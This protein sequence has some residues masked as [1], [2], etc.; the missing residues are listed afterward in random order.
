MYVD[1]TLTI[2]LSKAQDEALTK[3]A[4]VSGKTR[5]ELVREFIDVGLE[6]V[7]LGHRIGHVKG[8]LNLHEPKDALR[9]RI[10]NRNWR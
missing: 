6:E 4:R 9:R 5:S 3:K 7:P 1:K 2:R 8:I 10:K